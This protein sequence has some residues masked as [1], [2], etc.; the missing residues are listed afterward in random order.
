M[1][2]LL[3]IKAKGRGMIE[4]GEGC[5]LR[6]EAGPY[7]AFFE[8]EKEDIAIENCPFGKAYNE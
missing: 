6:E 5:Q 1:K 2:A 3:G 8:I 4:D 7:K